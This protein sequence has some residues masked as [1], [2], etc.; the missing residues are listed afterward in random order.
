MASAGTISVNL[1]AR[2]E[3]FVRGM[4]KSKRKIAALEKATKNTLRVVRRFG[5]M[6]AAAAV[7]GVTVLT[8]RSLENIDAIAKLSDRLNVSTEFLSAFGHEAKI[9]GASQEVF[10]KGLQYMLK[11]IGEANMGLKSYQDAFTEIGLS[12]EE[13]GEISPEEAF[14]KIAKRLRDVDSASTRTSVAMRI[15]GRSGSQLL[16]MMQ[17]D[18]DGVIDRAKELGIAFSREMA[19]KVEA[20]NDAITRMQA[21]FSGIGNT[22]A[23]AVA[24]YIEAIANR[25]T[26][27]TTG[28]GSLEDM[29][30]RMEGIAITATYIADAFNFVRAIINTIVAAVQKMISFT[31]LLWE[32]SAT[33]F[34]AIIGKLSSIPGFKTLGFYADT[35]KTG[36]RDMKEAFA[37]GAAKNWE[38]AKG[39]FLGLGKQREKLQ[40]FFEEIATQTAATVTSQATGIVDAIADEQDKVSKKYTG[41]AEI[42]SAQNIKLEGFREKINNNRTEEILDEMLRIQRR[43]FA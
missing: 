37:E 27:A 41:E 29:Q 5:F 25:I 11:N 19:A 26:S 32:K 14:I 38:Q 10:S 23:I 34:E 12:F 22:L 8:K 18:L 7:A 4:D 1:I 28:K 3:A 17:G 2:T 16:N 30:K 42:F 24:P 43:A 36:T 31:F 13:L 20:A 35:L 39:Q 6:A 21:G 33:M 15:F 40:K 9:A